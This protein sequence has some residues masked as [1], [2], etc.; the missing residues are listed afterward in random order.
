[1]A[2]LLLSVLLLVGGCVTPVPAPLRMLEDAT[3]TGCEWNATQMRWHYPPDA[4]GNPVL[5]PMYDIT[6][7]AREAAADGCRW[8]WRCP[9]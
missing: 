5:S 8:Q 7:C 9:P 6:N 1:M 2:R 4:A 3:A